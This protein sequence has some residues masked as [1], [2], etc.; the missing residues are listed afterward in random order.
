MAPGV[1][2]SAC[3]LLFA[4]DDCLRGANFSASATFDASI[5]IDYIDVAF[6]DCF[7]GAVGEASAA[8]NAFVCNYVSHCSKV[9]KV[10][11]MKQLF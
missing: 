9:F 10:L 7:N 8:S 3:G 2:F 4:G 11:F 5:G 6:R 1:I